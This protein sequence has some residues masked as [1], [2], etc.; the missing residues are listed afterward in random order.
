MHRLHAAEVRAVRGSDRA[1]EPRTCTRTCAACSARRARA[2]SRA[3]SHSPISRAF[4]RR[5]AGKL[6]GG[7][8]QKLG[9][10]CVLLGEPAGAAARRTPRRRRS[11]LAAR[12][13]ADGAPR[14]PP[15]GMTVVWSTSYLD[16]AERCDADA[17]AE[18]RASSSTPGAPADS[19]GRLT[20]RSVQIAG[21]AGNRRELLAARAACR[22]RS[23]T[24]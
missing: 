16:E 18:R 15:T 9:L 11:D 22:L 8:K 21:I 2:A 5:P 6:S 7:M 19:T 17:A 24:A 13:V 10:A 1:G 4:T 12:T 14:W 20:G 3:C 23:W